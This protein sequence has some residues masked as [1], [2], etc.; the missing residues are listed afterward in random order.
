ML[1]SNRFRPYIPPAGTH[2]AVVPGGR[3]LKL[4]ARNAAQ[5]EAEIERGLPPSSLKL[6]ADAAGLSFQALAPAI[7]L[8]YSTLN[9][10]KAAQDRLD[11]DQSARAYRFAR[12]FERAAEVLGGD[13]AA[14]SWLREPLLPLGNRSPLEALRSDLGAERV[15]QLL[16]R[17]D[18]GV[19]S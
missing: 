16:E 4:T 1:G 12:L 5:L 15:T 8:S 2:T 6:L 7:G 10:R 9:R 13:D 17:L 11:G 19:Y 18:D 3:I 14:R